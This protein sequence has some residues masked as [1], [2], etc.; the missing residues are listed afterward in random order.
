MLLEIGDQKN[1]NARK[2]DILEAIPS[3]APS[4]DW[5]ILVAHDD[6]NSIEAEGRD[7]GRFALTY[8]TKDKIFDAVEPVDGRT[9]KT[10]MADYADRNE[11]WRTGRQW[12][13]FVPSTKAASRWSKLAP[14]AIPVVVLGLIF[15]GSALWEYADIGGLLDRLPLP[16]ALNTDVGRIVLAFFTLVVLMFAVAAAVKGLEMRRASK[17]PSTFGRITRSEAGFELKRQSSDDT[18]TNRRV[19]KIEY[20]FTVDG[21]DYRAS[22]INLAEI[23]GEE[24]VDGFLKK[25]PVG[26]VA[27]VFYDS[28]NPANAV[29]ERDPPSQLFLGCLALL[30]IGVVGIVGILWFSADGY[31]KLQRLLPGAFLPLMIITGL[32][33]LICLSLFI[34]GRRALAATRTWPS[35]TGTVVSSGTHAFTRPS[36]SRS[37]GSPTTSYMPVVEYAYEV[38]GRKLTSRSVRFQTEIAG[39]QN[40]AE[41]ISAAY[42]VGKV[43]KVFYDPDEP[44]RTA[45]E[46]RSGWLWIPLAL[47]IALAAVA[48]VS[49]GIFTR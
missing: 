28:A 17:W 2:S 6:D 45:L 43:V 40:Y 47:G 19:P 32:G 21:R 25:Y 15:F 14:F 24:E 46:F 7:D 27:K 4:D 44:S 23:I 37:G 22:R 36:S 1:E 18:P 35:T 48:V 13:E 11:R 42:P 5:H 34:A 31:Q 20:Q 12:K 49:S 41:K 26:S 3:A 9:L 30:A 39:S 10:I 8:F 29:L 38:A 16:A 33:A